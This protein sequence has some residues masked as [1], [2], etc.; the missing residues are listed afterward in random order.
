MFAYDWVVPFVRSVQKWLFTFSKHQRSIT[1]TTRDRSQ[2]GDEIPKFLT[3]YVK[4]DDESNKGN[5][6]VAGLDAELTQEEE[7]ITA[8]RCI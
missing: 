2:W 8:P 3:N 5:R 1:G 4:Q 7:E 6:K